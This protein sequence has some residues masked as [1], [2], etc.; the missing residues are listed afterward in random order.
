MERSNMSESDITMLTGAVLG[1]N[2]IVLLNKQWAG[3]PLLVLGCLF[4]G[5]S[6]YNEATE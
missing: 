3:L 6:L 1:S 5:L 2:A 4:I